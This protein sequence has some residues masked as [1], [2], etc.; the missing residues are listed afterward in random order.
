MPRSADLRDLLLEIAYPGEAGDSATTLGDAF[1]VAL[2]ADRR[3]VEALL[4]SRLSVDLASLPDYYRLYFS[5]PWHRIYTLNV[6]D[7]DVAAANRFDLT[8]RLVPISATGSE[9]VDPSAQAGEPSLEVVHLN[10]MIG[11]SADRLTFSE[12][13]YAERS[14]AHDSWYAR[15][16][17]DVRSRPVVYVGTTLHESALWHHVEMRRRQRIESEVLPPGSVLVTKGLS[18][19]RADLLAALNVDWVDCTAEEFAITV[20]G[21]LIDEAAKGH[22]F[23]RSH[24]ASVG[25]A[26]IPLVSELAAERPTLQTDYLMGAEPHWSDL[27]S[28]RACVRTSDSDLLATATG[29]LGGTGPRT[30]LLVTGTAG[31][32]KSTALMRLALEVSNSGVPALWIDR[33]STVSPGG[34]RKRLNEFDGPLLVAIDDADVFGYQLPMLLRDHVPSRERLLVAFAVR[35]GKVDSLLQPL[36]KSKDVAIAEH[37]VPNLTDTDIDGLISVLDRNNRLGILKG[38]SDSQRRKAFSDKA[39]RQLLVAMIEATSGE[40]F[41]EKAVHELNELTGL[42]QFLYAAVSVA[43]TH[44]HYL[45]KDEAILACSGLAGDSIEAVSRLVARHLIVANPPDYQHR[46][47][48]R[49][50]AEVVSEQLKKQGQLAPVLRGLVTAI[51]SKVELASDRR[52][53][54]WRFLIRLVNHDY[55][56]NALGIADARLIYE[57]IES[58]LADDYHYWLQRG[59]LEVEHGDLRRAELFLNQSKS[60][61]QD[62]Y[63]VDT[64]YAYLLL[65]KAIESPADSRAARWMDEGTQLLEG[66]IATRGDQDSYCFHVLGAQGLSWARRGPHSSEEKRRLLTYYMNVVEQGLKKHPLQR[67]LLQLHS[68]IKQD[69]LQT[70]MRKQ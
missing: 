18:R 17:A 21:G 2:R 40:L 50:I 9:G 45:T 32:G 67:D 13:Q 51:A 64:E 25:R 69:Y 39:G 44:R 57:G 6:D 11:G 19:A 27:L 41:E 22:A 58:L 8:R 54:L 53:R 68:D 29:V 15:C 28:G 56:Y 34:I 59:S 5:M 65:R 4:A 55:L 66:V 1:A 47:R 38:A 20:L 24:D 33:D 70:A 63:R 12:Q 10:G 62:D 35:S 31:A 26:G 37:V 30:A 61:A 48:H 46:A 7:L 49:V 3:A 60:L 36:A 16:A 14:A 52:T 42:Q 23:L 43:T